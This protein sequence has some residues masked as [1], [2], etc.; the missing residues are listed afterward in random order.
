MSHRNLRVSKS[1]SQIYTSEAA[2]GFN[3]VS[4]TCDYYS[5]LLS[6]ISF[7]VWVCV[8]LTYNIKYTRFS[9]GG[10]APRTHTLRKEGGPCAQTHDT[11]SDMAQSR[12]PVSFKPTAFCCRVQ[13]TKRQIHNFSVT[14][15]GLFK[16]C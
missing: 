11:L 5:Y 10:R 1:V 14:K 16:I 12:S 4:K 13:T 6:E 9:D 3:E 7:T 15:R 8:T 2:R